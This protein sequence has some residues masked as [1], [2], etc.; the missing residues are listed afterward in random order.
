MRAR[1]RQLEVRD[2]LQQRE[3][4]VRA[5]GFPDPAGSRCAIPSAIR[6]AT[7]I[8]NQI[9]PQSNQLAAQQRDVIG[10]QTDQ[11]ARL[12][13]DVLDVNR[14][15]SG[16]MAL[17]RQ[18]VNLVE[19]AGKCLQAVTSA[20][21]AK[22]QQLSLAPGSEAIPLEGDAERLE[23]VIVHLLANAVQYTP[24]GGRIALTVRE[25][26][27]AVIRVRDTGVGLSRETL[28]RLFE[29]FPEVKSALDCPEG[30]LRIGLTLVRRLVELHGGSVSAASPGPNQ[31]SEFIVRLPLH[32]TIEPAPTPHPGRRH[33]VRRRIL[34][35]EDNP[36]GRE[37]LRLML[38]LWG[39]QVEEASDGPKGVQK[40]LATRPRWR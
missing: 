2:L 35:I 17:Q 18:P 36:D 24:R 40:A 4:A 14:V 31:G 39:H 38:Q 5:R 8:L 30:G 1:R 10:R 27:Q 37:T 3:E 21:Q 19:I 13:G 26:E 29:G 6:N 16:K 9:S 28:T 20:V 25:G 11:L 23:Q 22:R 34:L 12:I 7:A 32:G 15:T 33:A